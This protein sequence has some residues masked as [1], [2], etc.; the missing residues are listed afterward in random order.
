[1]KLEEGDSNSNKSATQHSGDDCPDSRG[2]KK[3]DAGDVIISWLLTL[4]D[5]L[6]SICS[7]VDYNNDNN[8]VAR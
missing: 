8:M 7:Q 4:T 3:G 1:M 6:K 5:W 2:S